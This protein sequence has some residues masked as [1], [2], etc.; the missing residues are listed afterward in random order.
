MS[1]QKLKKQCLSYFL[2]S[3][4]QLGKSFVILWD[5]IRVVSLWM[6]IK[7]SSLAG[8]LSHHS[9]IM[10]FIFREKGDTPQKSYPRAMTSKQDKLRDVKLALCWAA[11]LLIFTEYYCLMLPFVNL[12]DITLLEDHKTWF[13]CPICNGMV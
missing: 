2:P 10:I 7:I 3:C 1:R 13:T 5:C 6:I 8:V 4:C 11:I 9:S 12:H